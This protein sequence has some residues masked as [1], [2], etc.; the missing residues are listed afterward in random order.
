M[1]ILLSYIPMVYL[2][3]GPTLAIFIYTYLYVTIFKLLIF[4]VCKI[5]MGIAPPLP[6]VPMAM[7]MPLL[8]VVSAMVVPWIKIKRALRAVCSEK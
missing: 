2:S 1:D 5:L 7:F 4:L 6:P 8:N 3:I